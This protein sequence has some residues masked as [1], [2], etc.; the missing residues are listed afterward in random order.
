MRIPQVVIC[1]IQNR[2]PLPNTTSPICDITVTS[3][4]GYGC[5]WV[6]RIDTPRKQRAEDGAHAQQRGRRV[7]R[8]RPLERRDAVGDR[9][10]A[11]QGDRTRREA[12]QDQE[13]AE[14]A[15]RLAEGLGPVLVVGDAPEVASDALHHGEDEHEDD[16]DDV[17][18][19]RQREE[20]SRL[21]H[22]AQ[23]RQRDDDEERQAE[24][25]PLVGHP[26]E[27]RDRDDGGR[28]GRDRDG[29][30]QDVVD[31]QRGTGDERRD[32]AEVLAADDVGPAAA[33]VGEDRLAVGEDDDHE[34]DRHRDGDRRED[35]EALLEARRAG[36]GD[37]QDLFRRVGRRRDGVGRERRQR[38]GLGEALVLLLRRRD[39]TADE[40]P[41]QPGE[42]G[43]TLVP[44]RGRADHPRGT[45]DP[46][47]PTV[48]PTT[49]T[50]TRSSTTAPP[51]RPP[52]NGV[53][54]RVDLASPQTSTCGARPVRPGGVASRR[55]RRPSATPTWS[56]RALTWRVGRARRRQRRRLATLRRSTAT[57]RRAR[58]SSSRVA[59]RG[60][61]AATRRSRR[62]DDRRS[63]T[64]RR[65][66]LS[67]AAHRTQGVGRVPAD[68]RT[69]PAGLRRWSWAPA[70]SRPVLEHGPP[71][72]RLGVQSGRLSARPTAAASRRRRRQGRSTTASAT[73][74]DHNAGRTA[75]HR[76]PGLATGVPP[77]PLTSIRQLQAEIDTWLVHYNTRRR[78]HSDYMRGRTPPNSCPAR[79]KAA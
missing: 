67:L 10:D 19:G 12:P 36:R 31:E 57:W 27:L 59:G 21:L 64:G 26:V 68:A 43:G 42:H 52:A 73:V 56:S 78:N 13:Q 25:D 55:G 7:L 71:L 44:A 17:E 22:A 16:G 29:D 15:A 28:A 9:L 14:R 51:A 49:V 47:S 70:Q 54:R 3:V 72:P 18:V 33:R 53:R 37:E 50:P 6:A 8:F 20:P 66:R 76:P 2:N 75:R 39:R 32:P 65:R 23:V 58:S 48:Q 40:E 30:G 5:S 69:P 34:Q 62:L 77:T 60:I 35:V 4:L 1:S 63:A 45:G 24:L 61:A 41:L 79:L 74:A 11:R 46:G 38:D